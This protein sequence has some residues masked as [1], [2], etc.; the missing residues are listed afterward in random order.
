MVSCFELDFS[1]DIGYGAS[2]HM[3][4]RHLYILL[5]GCLLRSLACF[6]RCVLWNYFLS[7]CGLFFHSL[8]SVFPCLSILFLFS[9]VTPSALALKSLPH[10]R[11]SRV[12]S[13]S[14]RNFIVSHFA[15][16][17]V[18]QCELIF[19]KRCQ[20]F[21]QVHFLLFAHGCPISASCWDNCLWSIV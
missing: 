20:V 5:V 21:V 1:D 15:S 12:S 9:W 7:V 6:T 10:S 2:L 19:V 11:P 3:L 16:K 8:D 14:A 18:I 13:V 17:S 4:T